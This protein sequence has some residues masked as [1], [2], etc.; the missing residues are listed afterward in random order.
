MGDTKAAYRVLVGNL[1]TRDHLE[2]LGVDGKIIRKWIL[3]SGMR[4]WN[5]LNWIRTGTGSGCE[6]VMKF[7]F[8]KIR[9]IS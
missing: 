9:G 3:R 6:C 1:R 7:G 4:A 8:H 2:D 5:R